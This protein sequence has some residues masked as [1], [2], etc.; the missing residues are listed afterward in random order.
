MALWHPWCL[1]TP[2]VILEMG[3]WVCMKACSMKP[4]CTAYLYNI[5]PRILWT[6]NTSRWTLL[7]S[8]SGLFKNSVLSLKGDTTKT[9]CIWRVIRWLISLS[10]HCL[11]RTLLISSLLSLCS[12][13]LVYQA[14]QI[15]VTVGWLRS[16]WGHSLWQGV[17][18]WRLDPS[19]RCVRI[20]FK[21]PPIWHYWQYPQV[22]WHP[23]QF[24]VSGKP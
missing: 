6:L 19:F 18:R 4:S 11:S 8:V 9:W 14:S 16:Q 17:T 12:A 10:A 2:Q 24:S 21:I 1:T 7:V 22:F 15:V 13:E 20:N 5:F 23:L 3:C